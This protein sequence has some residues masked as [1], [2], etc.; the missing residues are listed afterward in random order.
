MTSERDINVTL[1]ISRFLTNWSNIFPIFEILSPIDASLREESIGERI[2]EI[3]KFLVWS[4]TG[5]VTAGRTGLS[6]HPDRVNDN[7]K[8]AIIN[9]KFWRAKRRAVLTVYQVYLCSLKII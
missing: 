6:D 4:V 7:L 2:F 9:S 3:G 8:V 5:G 1:Q